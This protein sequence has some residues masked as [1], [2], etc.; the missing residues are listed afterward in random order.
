MPDLTRQ[1]LVAEAN[2]IVVKV[3]TR[4]LTKKDGTLDE[5]QV[6]AISEQLYR[7]GAGGSRQVVLVSS[8]AVGAGIGK[9]G[10]T[11]RPTDLSVLQAAAALGQSHLIESYNQAFGEHGVLVAQVLLTSDVMSD[12]R[13]YLNVRNT[14]HALFDCGAVAIVNEN[15]TVRTTE[16][17]RHVGD[18]DQ[19]A[20]MVANMIDAPLLIILSD[21]DGVYDG[22]PNDEASSVISTLD[23][24]EDDS[25]GLVQ[26]TKQVEG[27][28][29]SRGGMQSK[30]DAAQVVTK[31]GRN[32]IIAGGRRDN[33]LVDILEGKKV[34][35]LILGERNLVNA[36]KR[37]IGWAAE[38]SGNLT[39]DDG[40]IA[41]VLK[42]KSLLP[43]GVRQVTGDFEKGDVVSICNLQGSE[44]GR[45]LS[46]YSSVDFAKIVGQPTEKLADLLG[47]QPYSVAIHRNDMTLK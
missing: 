4:V 21:V 2:P 10:L 46:N 36:R 13:R 30:L 45:G 31:A 34:G 39:L 43:V 19:L 38:P 16:L 8:G 1:S 22:D 15:D 32:V 40:A 11:K 35:T 47:R 26:A 28:V 3:G 23:L 18:N 17:A 5:D 12:R 25:N 27:P 41:A 44:V 7:I 20:A 9:M 14:L 33:V 6:A 29:I 37:W 24:S 42:G